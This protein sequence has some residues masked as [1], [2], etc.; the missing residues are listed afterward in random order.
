MRLLPLPLLVVWLTACAT[1]VPASTDAGASVSCHKDPRVVAWQPGLQVQSTDGSAKLQFVAADPSPPARDTTNVW[2]VRLSQAS[3]LPLAEDTTVTLAPFM[4]D[5]G[6]GSMS[7]PQAEAKGKGEWQLAPVN[8]FMPGVWRFTVTALPT[9]G[10]P[11]T[12]VWHLCI[13][14]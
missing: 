13:D 7:A 11:L 6:H 9:G 10:A 3:G 14:G 12:F 4:P 2:R 5:H 8:L 1:E